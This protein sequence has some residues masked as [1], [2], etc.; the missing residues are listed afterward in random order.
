MPNAIYVGTSI[1]GYIADREGKIDFLE[2]V[3][4]P[5]HLDLGFADFIDSIDALL[6]GRKTFETVLGFGVEWPYPKHV[7]VYSSS[8][9]SVPDELSDKVTIVGGEL[10]VVVKQ[11]NE[12]G[13]ERL[14]IDGGELIRSL[15]QEDKI[16][17][18]IIARLPVLL[19]GGIPLFGPTHV[20][21]D[22]EHVRTEVLLDAI[23]MTTYQRKR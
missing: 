12:K 10:D 18:M 22:F 4:N 1:D 2:S 21:L 14:Y 23:V 19:G 15:I 8:L 13:Y 9:T 6:M 20:H 3:P 5:E 7:F 11:L 17:R 16:E